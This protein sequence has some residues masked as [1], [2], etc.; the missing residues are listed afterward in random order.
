MWTI[1]TSLPEFADQKLASLSVESPSNL[2]AAEELGI[3]V[4]LWCGRVRDRIETT[5][6]T[7]EFS[8]GFQ[9]GDVV[10]E[11]TGGRISNQGRLKVEGPAIKIAKSE[12][13][14]AKKEGSIGGKLGIFLDKWLARIVKANVELSGRSNRS[15]SKREQKDSESMQQSWRVADAGHNYW[16]V[17]GSPLNSESVLEHKIIGEEPICYVVATDDSDEIETLVSFRCDLRDL[18]FQRDDSVESPIDRQFARKQAE[19]NRSAVSARVVALALHRTA[20][21]G[22]PKASESEV[23]LARQRLRAVR[24]SQ[25]ME[26]I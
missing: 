19:R 6:G 3:L 4:A 18:W 10:V 24:N 13:D 1:S 25:S 12:I 5:D 9:I 16:R 22:N 23:I 17:F 20:T 14:Q 26:S 11:P 21:D 15:I 8:F 2:R 7:Y